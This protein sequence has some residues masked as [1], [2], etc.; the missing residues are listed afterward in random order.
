MIRVTLPYPPTTNNLFI[1]RGKCRIKSPEYR[2]WAQEAGWAIK[3]QCPVHLVRLHGPYAATFTL[4]RPDKRA[5]DIANTEKALS[6]AL[7][8]AGIVR[9]D[10]DAQE[11]TLR[12]SDRPPGKG[13]Q[14]HVEV[15]A[16]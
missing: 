15:R 9:D 13:A 4:D 7:V 2:A 10:S 1:N 3:A 6:D 12:W 14:A 8:S 16:A 11:I 5:R